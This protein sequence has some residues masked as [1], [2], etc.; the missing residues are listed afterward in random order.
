MLIFKFSSWAFMMIMNNKK[1]ENE[2]TVGKCLGFPVQISYG[3][4][5]Y[6]YFALYREA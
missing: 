1:K 5:A 3:P 4:D 2:M 6:W